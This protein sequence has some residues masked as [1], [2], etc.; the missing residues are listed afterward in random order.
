MYKRF[1]S[2]IQDLT[3][4]GHYKVDDFA[5]KYAVSKQTIR[6]DIN[7]INK[8]LRNCNL[9]EVK[10]VNDRIE[11]RESLIYGKRKIASTCSKS[12]DMR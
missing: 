11:N 2:I 8:F 6:N 4:D 10:I 9:S 3:E 7:S 12:S 1:I 5:R